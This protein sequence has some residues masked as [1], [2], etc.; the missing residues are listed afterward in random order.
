[1]FIMDYIKIY[2]PCSVFYAT[3]TLKRKVLWFDTCEFMYEMILTQNT[4][5]ESLI[6]LFNFFKLQSGLTFYQCDR[7]GKEFIHKSSFEMHILAHDDIRKKQCPHCDR[8]FRSTSHLNRHLRIHV[9][10]SFEENRKKK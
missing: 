3:K 10:F 6:F 1:M 5:F 2:H 9:S 8:W 7:C 4:M